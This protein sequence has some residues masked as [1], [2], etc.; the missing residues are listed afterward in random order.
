ML[1]HQC[2]EIKAEKWYKI[3]HDMNA[4][5]CC[6]NWYINEI[7]TWHIYRVN[8]KEIIMKYDSIC[9]AKNLCI[10]ARQTG[11]VVVCS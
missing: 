5:I 9:I 11:C 3:L 10:V 7:D 8:V 1:G 6:Q 4:G 2:C